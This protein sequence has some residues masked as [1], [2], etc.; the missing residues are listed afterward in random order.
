MRYDASNIESPKT[1]VTKARAN[2]VWGNIV[3][4]KFSAPQVLLT[5]ILTAGIVVYTMSQGD[6]ISGNLLVIAMIA[7]IVVWGV[8]SSAKFGIT[9][10]LTAGYLLSIPGKLNIN[11][12]L[13]T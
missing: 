5:L 12:P 2:S 11:F 8:L 7:I 4:D 10:L 9:I 6:M 3:L 1:R 13:G